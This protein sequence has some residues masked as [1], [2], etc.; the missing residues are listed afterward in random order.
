V[1]GM[2]FFVSCLNGL[3]DSRLSVDLLEPILLGSSSF[4][5]GLSSTAGQP[6][7]QGRN[8]KFGA[9]S[10]ERGGG[11]ANQENPGASS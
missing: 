9:L 8:E 1:L 5:F 6:W 2:F 3:S 11:R 7:G 10:T 4:P